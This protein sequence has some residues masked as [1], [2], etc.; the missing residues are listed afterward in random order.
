MSELNNGL[1]DPFLRTLTTEQLK[2]Y[3]ELKRDALSFLV[4]QAE[5]KDWLE[6]ITLLSKR[7]P[8]HFDISLFNSPKKDVK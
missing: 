6:I 3:R 2:K 8:E 7:Q 4:E 1:V 5:E